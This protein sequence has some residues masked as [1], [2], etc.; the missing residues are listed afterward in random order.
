MAIGA[1]DFDVCKLLCLQVRPSGNFVRFDYMAGLTLHSLGHVDIGVLRRR[2]PMLMVKSSTGS[3]MTAQT[4]LA[5]WFL[6]ALGGLED[7]DSGS[8]N[9]SQLIP[10]FAH[11]SPIIGSMADQA[12]NI[13]EVSFRWFAD[14]REGPK[15]WM[16]LS[17]TT[18][19]RRL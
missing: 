17:A 1:I 9:E 14:C 15:S 6:N 7:I 12:V 16:A 13:V 10:H 8:G 11:C 19:L 2:H 4:H 3:R 18:W 5:G